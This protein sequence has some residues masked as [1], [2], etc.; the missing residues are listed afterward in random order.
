MSAVLCQQRG[1]KYGADSLALF[2]Y[3]PSRAA[4][5]FMC[6][7]H[8]GREYVWPIHLN[9]HECIWNYRTLL[10]VS[11]WR[12]RSSQQEIGLRTILLTVAASHAAMSDHELS[13]SS[14]SFWSYSLLAFSILPLLLAFLLPSNTTIHLTQPLKSVAIHSPDHHFT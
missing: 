11:A 5:R 2:S 12:P 13:I 8:S 6:S 9:P 7:S 1:E 14:D 3:Q 10:C 4:S